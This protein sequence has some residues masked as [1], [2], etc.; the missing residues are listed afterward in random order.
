MYKRQL[1]Y[2]GDLKIPQHYLVQPPVIKHTLPEVL[3]AAGIHEYALSL[4]LIHI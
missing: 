3:C 2:D 1:Q 4:S